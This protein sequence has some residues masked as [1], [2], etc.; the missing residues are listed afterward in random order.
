[1]GLQCPC[2]FRL[3]I[4][5]NQAPTVVN[6]SLNGVPQEPLQ[7]TINFSAE[8]CFTG[9]AMCNPAVDNFTV[10]F[11]TAQGSQGQTI[12]FT[13][14]RRGTIHCEDNT[15]A[16]LDDGTAQATGNVLPMGEYTVSFSYIIDNG[17][18]TVTIN[19]DD[20]SGN[21]FS[22]TFTAQVQDNPETFIGDCDETVGG[23]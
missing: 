5:G 22:T 6:Y 18:A 13:Q 12:N 16:F 7:G 14:G 11:G 21:T 23:Q 2:K 8:Q 1:M 10:N 3:G 4:E 19:A 9:A 17:I 20:G 15:A